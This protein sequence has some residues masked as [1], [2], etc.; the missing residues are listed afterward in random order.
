MTKSGLKEPVIEEKDN[1]VLVTIKHEPLASPEE[2]ILDY[3][4]THPFI[5]NKVAR[6]I[7]HIQGDYI[8]KEIF[9]RLVA[10]GLIQRVQ[11]TN[12]SSTSYEKVAVHR[13]NRRC[14]TEACA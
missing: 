7:C 9:N 11:G 4:E 10:R 3:L 5:R 2:V 12:T 14:C 1:S 6:E 13:C 8:V